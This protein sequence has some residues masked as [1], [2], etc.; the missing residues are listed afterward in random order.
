MKGNAEDYKVNHGIQCWYDK[1]IMVVGIL[2]THNFFSSDNADYGYYRIFVSGH[3]YPI[4]AVFK[5][6]KLLY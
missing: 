6:V 5:G 1:Y 3:L 4:Y 2:Y